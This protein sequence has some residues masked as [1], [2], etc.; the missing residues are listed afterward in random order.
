MPT[1]KE[2]NYQKIDAD[3]ISKS[4]ELELRLIEEQ[5]IAY[6]ALMLAQA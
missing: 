6:V 5:D 4:F 1:D 3:S 2:K